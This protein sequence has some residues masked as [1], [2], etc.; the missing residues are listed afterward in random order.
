MELR[1]KLPK[2]Y[3][4]IINTLLVDYG[5]RICSPIPKCHLCPEEI[6][7]ICPYYHKLKGI[8]GVLKKY[9]FKKVSRD[10][11]PE[12]KGTYIL[13]IKLKEPRTITY[14]KNRKRFK[15]GYYFYV[16]S[17]M[18]E[19]NNLRRRIERHLRE[20]KKLHWHIDYLL[21]YGTVKEVYISGEAVECEVARD[22]SFL[23]SIEGFGSSDCSCKSHLFFMES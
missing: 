12:E 2:K 18:G 4:K 19:S 3:W 23:K 21:Q 13:K 6:R 7:K 10:N 20:D 22:L 1:K 5:K 16:G 14:G 15:R 8:E 11:I 9:N 17:A